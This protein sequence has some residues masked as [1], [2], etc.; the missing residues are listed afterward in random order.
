MFLV[1]S[2]CWMQLVRSREFA[3]GVRSFLA[4]VP[5]RLL[6]VTDFSVNSIALN[7]ERR[8]QLNELPGFLSLSTIG[9]DIAI[10]RLDVDGIRRVVETGVLHG[11]DYDDAYQYTAAELYGLKLVSFDADFD[12]TPLGRLTPSAALQQFREEQRQTK[13]QT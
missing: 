10:V 7:M 3:P 13:Q 2:N 6:F 5:A 12:R 8:K 9:A 11:L 1:D 4:E